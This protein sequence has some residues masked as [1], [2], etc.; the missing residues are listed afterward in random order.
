VVYLFKKILHDWNDNQCFSK[1]FSRNYS[2]SSTARTCQL[3]VI[4]LVGRPH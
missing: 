1:N 4:S 3:H 2:P